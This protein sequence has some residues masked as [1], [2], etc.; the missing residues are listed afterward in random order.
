MIAT[1]V[2]I[3]WAHR[4][5]VLAVLAIEDA[6]FADPWSE[7]DFL[8]MIRQRNCICLVAEVEDQVVAFLLYELHKNKIAIINFAVHPEWR[9]SGVGTQ[10]IEKMKRKLDSY[11]RP[12]LSAV[13][14][15]G[16]LPAQQF[17]RSMG[18]LATAVLPGY[19]SDSGEDAYR[20]EFYL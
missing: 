14:R 8:R 9:R 11:Y 13:V 18:F 7:D 6:S 1:H 3:R 15:E 4:R 20:F 16:N 19:F 2:H 12:V 5:D 17:F 10:L